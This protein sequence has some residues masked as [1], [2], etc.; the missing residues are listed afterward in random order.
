MLYGSGSYHYTL[1]DSTG[2]ASE[3]SV[4]NVRAAVAAAAKSTLKRISRNNKN[5]CNVNI[6]CS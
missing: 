1:L 2:C 4:N 3:F 5:N 6:T